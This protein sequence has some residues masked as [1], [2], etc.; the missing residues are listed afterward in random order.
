[1]AI[2]KITFDRN[3]NVEFYKTLQKR[4]REYFKENNI[5]RYGNLNMVLKS[6]F[7]IS[8]YFVPLVL[9]TTYFTST[10]AIVSMW[11]LMGFGMT[12][13]GLSI[14][15]DANHGA[16]SKHKNV[17]R[18]FGFI[19]S[20]IGG[21]DVTWRMQHNVLHHT[22]TNVTGMDE[23]INP[24]KVMRFSPHEKRYAAHKYQHIYAWFLYGLMTISWCTTKDFKQLYRYKKMGITDTQGTSFSRMLTVTII[25]KIIYYA[26][27]LALP[28]MFSPMAWYG[29]ILCFLM[30]HF[31]S[32]VALA[33][34]FQPAHVVPS[35]TYP[36]PD[37]SGN[38]KADWAV[39]QL[40]NT[41]N[42]AQKSKWFTWYVGGLNHQVEHHLF[43]NI[44][45]VHYSNISKIVKK[46]AEEFSLPYNT[47]KTFFKALK[48]HGSM[49]KALGT[50]DDVNFHIH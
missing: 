39:S 36:L 44:C 22:Y 41:A 6:I 8:L 15:H 23:D 11:I 30:M 17:N 43:P 46:T 49:L 1:M 14:M 45:H 50:K 7:M 21:S 5:D 34:I 25:T 42:F 20:F 19:I 29:T 35:S 2:K 16:Y 26:I 32:G 37:E 18:F 3:H 9:I 28:L 27:T 31:I 4:V 38:I 13:I 48:V 33:A 24:G 47:Q 40:V 10:W 12:G